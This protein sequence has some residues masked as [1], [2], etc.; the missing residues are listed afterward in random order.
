[1]LQREWARQFGGKDKVVGWPAKCFEH[2]LVVGLPPTA[3]VNS[4]VADAI[5][6]Q[7]AK[8]V[9]ISAYCNLLSQDSKTSRATAVS[10]KRLCAPSTCCSL[11]FTSSDERIWLESADHMREIT[12][13]AASTLQMLLRDLI[14]C[15]CL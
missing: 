1:M 12:L 10:V 14:R 11:F 6:A 7:S 2:F 3:D 13:L 15:K 5:T 8:Q 4:A 9:C